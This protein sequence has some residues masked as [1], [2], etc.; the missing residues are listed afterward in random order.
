[1]T[2]V[3]TVRLNGAD[4]E[5]ALGSTLRD[6]V[7]DLTGHRLRDDGSRHDGGRLGVAAAVGGAVVPRSRW[8]LRTIAD[9]DDI[10]IV[11]AAQGG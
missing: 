7:A 3:H 5:V 10:E 8:A 2:T 6:I 1:M 4:H 9:G 11:T